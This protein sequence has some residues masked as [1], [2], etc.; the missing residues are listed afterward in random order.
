MKFLSTIVAAALLALPLAANAQTTNVVDQT[1]VVEKSTTI[2]VK[3]TPKPSPVTFTPYGFILL[4]AF[5]SDA[6]GAKNYPLPTVCNRAG[7]EGA[8]LIDVRQTRIG[9]RL[10]FDDTA[11][12]T[13]ATMAGVLEVDFQGNYGVPTS[14]TIVT[15][16]GVFYNP[17]IRLRKAYADAAWGKEFKFTLR[18]GQDDRITSPLRPLSFGYVSNTLFQFAG[19]L[20]GRA[21]QAQA[22]LDLTPKDGLS[23]SVVAG[24]LNPMENTGTDNGVEPG[25]AIDYGAGN[26]SRVPALEGRVAVGWRS[27]GMKLLEI[28]GWAGWQKNR[29]INPAP[30][31]DVDVNTYI[32][33]GDLDVNLGWVRAMGQIYKAYGYDVP[34][35]L[36]P[37][38][39]VAL[40]FAPAP[41]P[42]PAGYRYT[43]IGTNAVPSFSGWFQ[44]L[45]G[46]PTLFQLYGGWGGTQSPFN[47]YTGS[48]LAV[49]GTRVQNFMWA[50]GALFYAGK[51]WR[52]SAEYAKA[53]S[54]FYNGNT[55]T[56]G[57]IAV[58]SMLVF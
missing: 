10:A 6:P 41:V 12:W 58:N 31:T 11:G 8:I 32:Y 30:D 27:G 18:L 22:R 45:V 3:E 34:G 26:R 20:N 39:G 2:V 25:S 23:F 24:A 40:S 14:G 15:P 16:S 4:N 57:Q 52:F 50:A 49:A 19:V 13:G 9:A 29:Y 28:G 33:G 48:T 7:C 17:V 54:W 47:A 21:P 42:P 35:S 46:P 37:S 43:L 1:N 36:G 44:V 38:Q 5:F 51:N 56:Q 53:T 55:A